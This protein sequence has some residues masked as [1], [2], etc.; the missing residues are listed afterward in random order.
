MKKNQK[1]RKIM[2]YLN[3]SIK[4]TC[5]LNQFLSEITE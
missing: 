3:F 1:E 4:I 5:L 2:A